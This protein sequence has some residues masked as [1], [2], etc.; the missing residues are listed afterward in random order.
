MSAQETQTAA[1]LAT[2]LPE[3]APILPP[4]HWAAAQD[5]GGE[6]DAD[7]TVGED[8]A[9]STASITSSILKYRTLHGRT[10]HSEIGNAQYWA[11]N[12]ERQ[13]DSLDLLHHLFSLVLQ[14]QLFLAPIREPKKAIDIG[15]GTGDDFADRFP[16]CEVIGTDISPIQPTWTPQNLKFEIEDC[17]REWTFPAGTVDFVHIRYL[18]GSVLDWTEFFKQAY[19][20]LKPGGYLESYEASPS[21]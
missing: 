15:T 11:A 12:D 7:S 5:D 18:L 13:T 4:E 9:S 14:G 16:E 10:Y 20:V 2:A 3:I 1:P 8:F 6:D 17:T 21:I 19:K